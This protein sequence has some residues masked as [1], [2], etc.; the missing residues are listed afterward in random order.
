MSQ[1]W[2][3]ADITPPPLVEAGFVVATIQSMKEHFDDLAIT[4]SAAAGFIPP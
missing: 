2:H 4:P 1:Q 3:L